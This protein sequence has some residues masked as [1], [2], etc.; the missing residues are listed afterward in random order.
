MSHS[1]VVYVCVCVCVC[2]CFMKVLLGINDVL[3]GVCVC[4]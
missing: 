4:A 3:C 2:E 1:V